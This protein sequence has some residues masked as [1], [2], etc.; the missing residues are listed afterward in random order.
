[1]S[2]LVFASLML[3]MVIKDIYGEPL[4]HYSPVTVEMYMTHYPL[5]TCS[6]AEE[7]LTQLV[8]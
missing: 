3:G 7:D 8:D 6:F 1:M 5:S 4:R 2:L